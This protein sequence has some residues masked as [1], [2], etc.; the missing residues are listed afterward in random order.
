[1]PSQTGEVRSELQPGDT[2]RRNF[3]D[4]SWSPDHEPEHADLL[5]MTSPAANAKRQRGHSGQHLQPGQRHAG[6]C[7]E[8]YRRHRKGRPG[9][10]ICFADVLAAKLPIFGGRGYRKRVQITPRG[11]MA[12]DSGRIS[13]EISD[14]NIRRGAITPDDSSRTK[15]QLFAPRAIRRSRNFLRCKN[16]SD[17]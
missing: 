8:Q 6:I 1:M 17:E 11:C 15:I 13:R 12:P 7:Q 10:N 14:Q 3:T 16:Q 5:P 4:R 2:V 9:C